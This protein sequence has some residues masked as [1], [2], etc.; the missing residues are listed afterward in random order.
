MN[1]IIKI[2]LAALLAGSTL[3]ISAGDSQAMS[4][5]SY[6][7][8]QADRAA[9][10]AQGNSVGQGAVLGAGAGGLYG[11]LTGHGAGSNIVTGLALG[12][13]GGAILGGAAGND[14][15]KEVYWNVYHDCMGY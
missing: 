11:G 12:A 13:V 1:R 10:H 8:M 3:A 2:S 14:R 15:A 6:C 7:R 4:K 9:R 5:K